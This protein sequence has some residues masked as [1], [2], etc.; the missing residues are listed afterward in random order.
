MDARTGLCLGCYRSLDEIARW[1]SMDA[2]ERSRVMAKLPAR[3]ALL[4]PSSARVT[5]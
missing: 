2:A 3:Q 4:L 1:G 5:G